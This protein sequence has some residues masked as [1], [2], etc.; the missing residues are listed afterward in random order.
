V[1]LTAN[2]SMASGS[3]TGNVEF[4]SGG[5]LLGSSMISAG[6]AILVTATL[7]NASH[8]ITALYTGSATAPPSRSGVFVQ[9]VGPSAWK[10][11]ATTMTLT[12]SPDPSDLGEAIQLT[13]TV[14]GSSSAMPTGR[15][16]IMVDGMVSGD[17]AG[18][19][20]TPVSG[21]TARVSWV[22][23]GLAHGRHTVTATYLADPNYKGST[24]VVTQQVN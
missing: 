13:A 8:A 7:A 12:L 1:T 21:S 23:T 20:I 19:V 22:V 14:T 11:R 9:T 6:R 4:Y 10:N 18:Q 5:T 17:P 16:L 2:A 24:A 15:I 3:V